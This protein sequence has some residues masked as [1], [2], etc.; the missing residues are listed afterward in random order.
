MGTPDPWKDE[1]L[2]T[3]AD[4]RKCEF[5]ETDGSFDVPSG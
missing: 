4:E 1:S 5:V 2:E 3:A